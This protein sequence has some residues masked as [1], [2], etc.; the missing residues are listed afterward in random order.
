MLVFF[1]FLILFFILLFMYL[2]WFSLSQSFGTGVKET[3]KYIAYDWV[4]LYWRQ[5]IYFLFFSFSCFFSLCVWAVSL[6][7]LLI[8]SIS[9]TLV[10]LCWLQEA[11]DGDLGL[12]LMEMCLLSQAGTA[13]VTVMLHSPRKEN[14]GN[15]KT[16]FLT[17]HI[18]QLQ[19]SNECWTDVEVCLR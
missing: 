3:Q 12:A 1:L 5:G 4:T 10:N 14:K 11:H 7:A 16:F 19:C 13:N 2:S 18:S 8:C 6:E 9:Y 15:N 17:A